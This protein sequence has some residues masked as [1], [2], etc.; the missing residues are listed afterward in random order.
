MGKP[1]LTVSWV[2]LETLTP[3][4]NNSKIHDD[5]NVSAIAE[6]IRENGFRFPITA[7]HNEEGVAV[8][9]SG[10][11]RAMAAKGLGLKTVPV[12][13]CD[14]LDDAHRRLLAAV[15]N[16]AT[17]MTGYDENVRAYELDTLSDCFDLDNFGFEFQ[18]DEG[19]GTD[20]ELSDEEAP[21]SKT[22]TLQMSGEMF[23]RME[24]ILGKLDQSRY[25]E[26]NSHANKILEVLERWDAR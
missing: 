13:W 14:D 4:E 2:P 9:V 21:Q 8:I 5:A 1:D 19:F 25:C 7:W 15:D 22:V 23:E 10:H 17:T 6:S 16:Q 11:G 3:Y 24:E 12:V 18:L 26:G 20:F